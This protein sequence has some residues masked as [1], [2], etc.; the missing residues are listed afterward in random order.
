VATD[1]DAARRLAEEELAGGGSLSGGF[2]DLNLARGPQGTEAMRM[3]REVQPGLLCTV[4]TGLQGS[5]ESVLALFSPGHVDEWDFVSK[6]FTRPEI[7]QR[8]RQMIA[9]SQ[10]R[11]REAAQLLEIQRL[12]RELELWGRSLEARVAERTDQLA[13]AM[14]EIREKNDELVS[15]LETLGETQ[16]ELVQH[17]RMATIG[18]L[19]AGVARELSKPLSLTQQALASA[20]R[21]VDLLHSFSAAVEQIAAPR[22]EA[23]SEAA[24]LRLQLAETCR[25]HAPSVAISATV[26]QVGL[27]A[28]GAGRAATIVRELAAFAAPSADRSPLDVSRTIAAAIDFMRGSLSRGEHLEAE[29]PDLP[30]VEGNAAELQDAWL[31]LLRNAV[32]ATSSRA[33]DAR[34]RVRAEHVGGEVVVE[35]ADNGEGIA[36]DLRGRVFEPFFSTRGRKTGLGLSVVHGVVSRHGGT[37]EVG[38]DELSGTIFRV[39]LPVAPRPHARAC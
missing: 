31:Q 13:G 29:L 39:H 28:D 37:I 14:R 24:A 38:S 9:A 20:A 4:I 17:E 36:D 19:A 11:A 8:C 1:A 26:G 7:V 33:G 23:S 2:F 12:N 5:L 6:P 32:E 21:G 18:H 27:A 10:R 3:L 30:T 25:A 35:F 22:P 16:S 15:V 34:I